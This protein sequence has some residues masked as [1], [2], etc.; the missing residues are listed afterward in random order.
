M[1]KRTGPVFY[2]LLAGFLVVI[3]FPFFWQFI[4]SIKPPSELFGEKAFHFITQNPS[5]ENYE[6]VFTQRPFLTYMWNSMV[7]S[8]LTTL[9]CIVVASFAAFA[10]ARLN[11]KGK[12]FIL[13]I[14][15]AVSMFP[16]IATIAPIFMFLQ[17][18]DLT[19]SYLGLII[20]YTTFALPLA[21]WN[22]T[23]FYR[24]IPSDLEEAAKIDGASVMQTFRKVFLPLAMPGTFTTAIL[25]FIA[26]WNEFLFSLTIN[27]EENLK[28]VPVGIA[29]FQGQYTIPWGE[30]AAASVI[31]TIPLVIMVLIFQRRII[32]GITAGAVKE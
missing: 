20:P 29:L 18:V 25:V 10:I 28:T 31:V 6:R 2:I 24:K 5:L 8:T 16:Q 21:I 3:M 15:L 22:L 27:T 14:V 17:S 26:A 23:T 1:Q 30:I 7:V 12:T 13:G 11:F 4:A 32:S 19:N 9:Y